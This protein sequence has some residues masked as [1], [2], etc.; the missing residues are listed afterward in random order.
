MRLKSLQGINYDEFYHYDTPLTVE[1]EKEALFAAGFS[2][3]EILKNWGSTFTLK[4][5]K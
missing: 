5:I 3:V 2:S 1:H 4:A